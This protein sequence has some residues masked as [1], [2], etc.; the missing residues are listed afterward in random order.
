MYLPSGKLVAWKSWS[1]LSKAYLITELR[2][3]HRGRA[4]WPELLTAFLVVQ[5]HDGSGGPRHG[6]PGVRE[7]KNAPEGVHFFSVLGGNIRQSYLLIIRGGLD[8]V[9]VDLDQR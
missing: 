2:G 8:R 7:G 3:E 5:T 4:S 1:N 9:E 6:L